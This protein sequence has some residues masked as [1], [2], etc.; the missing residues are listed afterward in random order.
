MS[1]GPGLLHLLL[2]LPLLF[3]LLLLLLKKKW[4]HINFRV[5]FLTHMRRDIGI[6]TG[7]TS[8]CIMDRRT[9]GQRS[10][11]ITLHSVCTIGFPSFVPSID[12]L[13]RAGTPSQMSSVGFLS[14]PRV[15]RTPWVQMITH[16]KEPASQCPRTHRMDRGDKQ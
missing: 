9:P 14:S 10:P 1:E 15:P 8:L 2:C 11:V 6:L 16:W 13:D 7:I 5:F 3:W 12:S 4:F